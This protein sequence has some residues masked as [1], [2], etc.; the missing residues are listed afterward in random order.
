MKIHHN[1][2]K[3]NLK[4]VVLI[5]LILGIGWMTIEV[6]SLSFQ[7]V[8]TTVIGCLQNEDCFFNFVEY[9]VTNDR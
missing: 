3:P 8:E 4:W 2:R 1:V 6:F 7:L 9:V 5:L